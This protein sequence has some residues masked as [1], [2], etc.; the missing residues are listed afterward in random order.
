MDNYIEIENGSKTICLSNC[1]E[2]KNTRITVSHEI[3][4]GFKYFF[5]SIA[6]DLQAQYQRSNLN[7]N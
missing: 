7:L 5:T 6:K 1:D 3:A 2:V 4:Y